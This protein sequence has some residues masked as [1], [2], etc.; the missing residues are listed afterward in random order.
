[1]TNLHGL[2]VSITELIIVGI[3]L[4]NKILILDLIQNF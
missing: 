2:E 1:M 4:S 3:D